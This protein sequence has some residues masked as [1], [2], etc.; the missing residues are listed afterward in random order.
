METKFPQK[1][2]WH[3][4]LSQQPALIAEYILTTVLLSAW[5]IDK[6]SS[7]CRTCLAEQ[8]LMSPMIYMATTET[9]PQTD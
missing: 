5:T 6:D 7:E 1:D 9:L 3:L 8:K 2:V 4:E